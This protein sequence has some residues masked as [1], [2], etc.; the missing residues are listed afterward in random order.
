MLQDQARSVAFSMPGGE[1]CP[2]SHGRPIDLNH[3]R[4]QT[5]GDR[6][7]EQEVLKLFRQQALK[8]HDRMEEAS[9]DEAKQLAHGLLGAA[10]GVGAK[11]VADAAAE[12]ERTPDDRALRGRLCAT[13]DEVRG[14]I[15]A[16]TR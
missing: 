12:V 4:R 3:L 6:S 10:R 13:I 2:V 16:V 14:F 5:M 1:R 9:A 7:L 8:V 11:C 15:A